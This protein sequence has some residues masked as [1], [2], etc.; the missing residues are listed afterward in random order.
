[1]S[2]PSMLCRE[3]YLT[4][5]FKFRFSIPHYIFHSFF[6]KSLSSCMI[7][8]LG[9]L[10]NMWVTHRTLTLSYSFIFLLWWSWLWWLCWSCKSSDGHWFVPTWWGFD[11]WEQWVLIS[12]NTLYKL[13]LQLLP[14][15]LFFR[16][17]KIF[18]LMRWF[19]IFCKWNLLGDL[20]L[21]C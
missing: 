18:N 5:T 3:D 16:S 10:I 8:I 11:Q 21:C 2:W 6:I 9:F 4:L 12:C 15:F 7:P 17:N 19:N 20:S 1:M 13:F 14:L